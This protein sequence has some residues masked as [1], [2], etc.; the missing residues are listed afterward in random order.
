MRMMISVLPLNFLKRAP[1]GSGILDHVA[2]SVKCSVE[3]DFL[4]TGIILN[5]HRCGHEPCHD[6]NDYEED[7]YDG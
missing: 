3:N 5:Y 4:F 1:I 2:V 6:S 7:H